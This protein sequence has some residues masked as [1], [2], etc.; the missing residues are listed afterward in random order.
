MK[1]SILHGAA[2]A[3]FAAAMGMAG[4]AAALPGGP[5]IACTE[6][7][8]GQYYTVERYRPATGWVYT[9]YLC[10]VPGS[11]QLYMVCDDNGCILY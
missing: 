1:S 4:D 3:L 7:L 11:W 5:P 10:D 2:L 9:T 6:A 8:Y